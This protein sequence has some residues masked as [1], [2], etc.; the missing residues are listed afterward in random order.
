MKWRKGKGGGT[1]A[2]GWMM[3]CPAMRLENRGAIGNEK[4]DEGQG[5]RGAAIAGGEKTRDW[6]RTITKAKGR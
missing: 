3:P 2:V 1:P 5:R 6:P 4:G